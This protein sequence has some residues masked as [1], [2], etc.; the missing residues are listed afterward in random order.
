MFDDSDDIVI[1]D[2]NNSSEALRKEDFVGGNSQKGKS[3]FNH[4]LD[5]KVVKSLKLRVETPLLE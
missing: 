3:A 5:L 1:G 4:N 2:T